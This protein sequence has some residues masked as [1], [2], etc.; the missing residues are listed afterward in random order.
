[1]GSVLLN[2]D[3]NLP[4]VS[5]QRAQILPFQSSSSWTVNPVLETVFHLFDDEMTDKKVGFCLSKL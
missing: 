2:L 5:A 3:G 4:R 1:M